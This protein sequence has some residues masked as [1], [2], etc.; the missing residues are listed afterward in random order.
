MLRTGITV[1]LVIAVVAFY[2]RFLIAL[3]KDWKPR[4]ASLLSRRM[5]LKTDATSQIATESTSQMR[6]QSKRMVRP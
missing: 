4:R 2:S 3:L 6:F 1:L 5:Q